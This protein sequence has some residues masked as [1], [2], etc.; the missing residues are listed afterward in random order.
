[1]IV[2]NESNIITRLFD[3][4]ISIIDC[5]CICDT[6]STDDTMSVIQNYF[7]NKN[8]HGKIISCPFVNFSHN[9]NFAMNECIG[10][11]DYVLVLD[12]DMSVIFNDNF[13]KQ[14]LFSKDYF[15]IFQGTSDFYY[16][17]IRIFKNNGLYKYYGST[18]EYLSP[19]DESFGCTIDKNTFFIN[20]IG[21]GGC[22]INKFQ[23][24]I[25]LLK[26]E[27]ETNPTNSRSLFYLANSYY[28]IQNYENAITYY[29][30][31]IEH[32]DN[33]EEKWYS[34]YRLGLCNLNSN[35]FIDALFI[36]LEGYEY[37]PERLEGIYEIIKYYRVNSKHKIAYQFYKITENIIHT[38]SRNDNNQL[39]NNT[40]DPRNNYLFFHKDVY[41]YKLYYEYTIIAFYN[42]IKNINEELIYVLNSSVETSTKKNVLNNLKFYNN[43]L[44]HCLKKITFTDTINIGGIKFYSS[45]SCLIKKYNS[46]NYLMNVRYVN[47]TIN[48]NGSYNF[49]GSNQIISLNKFVEL[50]QKLEIIQSRFIENNPHNTSPNELIVGI[51]DIRIYYNS[52]NQLV[53]IGTYCNNNKIGISHGT[54][55]YENNTININ[56]LHQTFSK[57]TCEK[58]WIFTELNQA[59]HV[60]YEWA[61]L[62]ICTINDNNINPVIRK[63]MPPLFSFVRGSTCGFNYKINNQI[64]F[65]CHIVSYEIPIRH[66]YHLFVV[67]DTDMNL[68]N[69]SAPFK[70]ENGNIEYCLSMLIENNIVF[71]NYSK[72]DKST[73]IALYNKSYIDSLLI[74]N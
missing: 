53:F 44:N 47:Y 41:A 36:W 55:D 6:G 62:V 66:Y 7:E 14:S 17:N 24:D 10:M 19:P 16:K 74:Y 21:D 43:T 52:S 9:R 73:E 26:T 18:H 70:F 15:Y 40:T 42:G 30:K 56:P 8:I 61:P 13:N 33:K 2:K 25:E 72:L 4:I 38:F 49:N 71:I 37:Y 67:F 34:Y 64:W 69:Y 35:N 57:T 50:N 1:M 31:C 20:D 3:S 29:L 54:Y 46:S 68:L 39:K 22:K 45:S 32:S 60:I 28:D 11:S 51:E 58:N 65:I 23:R 63:N 27:L 59:T 12:A 5:Y 48:P